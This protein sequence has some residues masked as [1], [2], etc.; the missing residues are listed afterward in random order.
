[1]V[2]P[3]AT[4]TPAPPQAAA[5][6][7]SLDLTGFWAPTHF[8]L[9][10]YLEANPS[11]HCMMQILWLEVLLFQAGCSLRIWT[12]QSTAH[13]VLGALVGGPP[14]AHVSVLAGSHGRRVLA[15]YS[16]LLF[17]VTRAGSRPPVT[18]PLP[19]PGL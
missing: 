19:S 14:Q 1:M 17:A 12:I 16:W 18:S 13:V 3:V 10:G 8:K 5:V 15:R 2:A 9:P 11:S 6:T 7:A 4:P